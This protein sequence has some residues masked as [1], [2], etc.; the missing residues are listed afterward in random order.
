[1]DIA[2]EHV[3]YISSALKSHVV[4][5]HTAARDLGIHVSKSKAMLLN[6]YQANKTRVA[7]SFVATGT[8]LGNL[9]VRVFESEADLTENCD[10]FF[11]SVNTVHVYSLLANTN[12]FTLVAIAMEERI[13]CTNLEALDTYWDLGLIQGPTLERC[14]KARAAPSTIPKSHATAQLRPTESEETKSQSTPT[15]ETEKPKPKLV[16]QSRKQQPK[17]SLLSSYVS[18]KS[19]KNSTT[20]KAL[21]A[22]KRALLDRPLYEYK[23]RKLEQLQPKERVVVSTEGDE[24]EVADELMEDAPPLTKPT[25][26]ESELHKMFLDDFT[27]DEKVDGALEM[28]VDQPIVVENTENEQSDAPMEEPAEPEIPQAL[29]LPKNDIWKSMSSASPVPDSSTAKPASPAPETTVDDDG[30]FT[31]YKQSEPKPAPKTDGKKKQASVMSFFLK[32]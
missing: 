25:V 21:G 8:R 12:S 4:T 11:D 17:S 24:N 9:A 26:T 7:A 16:Y 6:Y 28:E 5:Y 3:E 22:P 1:M 20:G 23:S 14:L 19:E 30:Y 15:D 29:L 13:H 2:K 32:R 18:R 27:D 31:L 10:S